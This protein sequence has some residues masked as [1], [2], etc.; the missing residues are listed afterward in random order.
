MIRQHDWL[1]LARELREVNALR[2]RLSVR[3]SFCEKPCVP[4]PRSLIV[5][6]DITTRD[7]GMAQGEMSEHAGSLHREKV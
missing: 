1:S 6:A 5:D 7:V 4:A 2:G 3:R